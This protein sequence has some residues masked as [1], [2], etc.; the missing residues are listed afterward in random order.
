MAAVLGIL[1]S[2]ALSV[3]MSYFLVRPITSTVGAL[4]KFSKGDF[5]VRLE[6][7][8]K[9]EFGEMNQVFNST[10]QKVEKLLEEIAHSRVLNKEM[11]FKAL[12]AQINPHFLYNALDTINW[13]AHKEGKDDICDMVSA[14]SNLL[15]ISI[16]NKEAVF[17]V[18][19]ELRYVKDYLYIQKTRYRNR[20]E[21][22]F[23]IAP[24]IYQQLIPKLTIQPLVENAIVH[25]VEV[26][27]EKAELTVKG[28]RDGDVVLICVSD[29]GVGMSEETRKALLMEPGSADRQNINTAHTGLGVYAVH[30]R[31]K[32]LFGEGYGLAVQSSPGEGTCITIRIPFQMSTDEVYA[33]AENLADRR[34]ENGFESPDS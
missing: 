16:S 5:K 27:R 2:L 7:E 6:E 25:S 33:R 11:E 15:R 20:F 29:T 31:L 1:L 10:I 13:M 23:D 30:Q 3:I 9:D 19:K 12:Q 21:V 28:H 22:V 18:E 32:Y 4:K 26:S 8:R 17:T 24:E 34:P 14:V